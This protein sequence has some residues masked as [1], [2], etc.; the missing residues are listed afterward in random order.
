M[1]PSFNVVSPVDNSIYLKREYADESDIESAL[2][3]S[4]K[5]QQIWRQTSL[6]TRKSICRKVIEY[7]VSNANE[8]GHELTWQMGRPIQ[9]TATEIT[10]GFE[11]R[12]SHMIDISENALGDIELE[13]S[14]LFKRFIRKEPLGTVFVLSPWNYPFLTAVNVIIPAILAGNSVI[15][16]HAAQTP[17]CAERFKSSF[18]YAGLPNGVFQ[19]LHLTHGHVSRIIGDARIDYVAFTGSVKG[20]RVIQSAVNRR[21]I[22][23]GLELGGKDPAYVRHDVDLEYAV[24]NLVDGA[25][26]NSGQSCCGIERIYVHRTIFDRFVE[27]FVTLTKNYTLDN[28][29]LPNTTLG[30]MVRTTA[31]QFVQKQIDQA[32]HHGAKTLVDPRTFPAHR[33]DSPYLAPQV[34]I[35]VDHTMDVMTQE[36]FGPVVGIAR[37]KDDDEAIR[38]MND[39]IYGLSASIWSENTDESLVLGDRIET[40]TCYLN[41]CDYL[42]PSLAW[43]GIKNS[44]KGCTLSTLGFDAF[45]RPKSF[46]FKA[47]RNW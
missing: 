9:Y 28:P 42:D 1:N 23:C 32:V 12:A 6:D 13:D 31:A 39:S 19:F 4:Q 2:D 40:G 22:S 25:F 34:L 44:G 47:A 29:T 36:S 37:V 17:L 26:F 24:E 7:F 18:D 8:I 33:P 27:N 14:S 5:M 20:G 41:R 45:T 3:I 38:L 15:L 35:D 10:K 43:T 30:P 11:E 16:K 21:F 46:H